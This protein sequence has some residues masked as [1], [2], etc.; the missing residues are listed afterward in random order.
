[1][2]HV[3]GSTYYLAAAMAHQD[4]AESGKLHSDKS[5]ESSLVLSS[6]RNGGFAQNSA[7]ERMD[8]RIL[9]DFG[10]GLKTCRG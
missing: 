10:E 4:A 6:L 9:G 7:P 3:V 1:M 2:E 5:K 8:S